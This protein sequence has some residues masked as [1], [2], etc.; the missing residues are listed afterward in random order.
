MKFSMDAVWLAIE[1]VIAAGKEPTVGRIVIQLRTN[2]K[3]FTKQLR[4]MDLLYE[5]V[6]HFWRVTTF[7]DHIIMT[8]KTLPVDIARAGQ[9]LGLSQEKVYE[10][11][12]NFFHNDTSLLEPNRR[13]AVM[14]FLCEF[15]HFEELQPTFG[16]LI[17]CR[18]VMWYRYYGVEIDSGLQG[19]TCISALTVDE[20]ADA[21]NILGDHFLQL[22]AAGAELDFGSSE[23]E[24]KNHVVSD[25][26]DILP[27][28]RNHICNTVACHGG[29]GCV[30]F[31][32]PNWYETGANYIAQWLGF[33]SSSQYENWAA[34]FV[35]L[36]GTPGG[37][38]MFN[39]TGNA[40]F[41]TDGSEVTLA[42]IGK[43]Y[44]DLADRAPLYESA[45]FTE[46]SPIEEHVYREA[47]LNVRPAIK[48]K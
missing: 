32:T 34:H 45:F 17:Y 12:G 37:G 22:H 33:P 25:N 7:M 40:A 30:L 26:K 27:L 35:G 18:M 38:D 24:Y 2:V 19:P 46:S 23:V 4:E 13:N 39:V 31:D 14:D 29:W 11:H 28:E 47:L 1:S 15:D 16:P 44:K 8:D 42:I 10:L 36:W 6:L 20:F 5:N 21:A 43:H 9:I 48:D 3:K 41:V